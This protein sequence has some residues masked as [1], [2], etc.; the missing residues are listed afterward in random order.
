MKIILGIVLLIILYL[1]FRKYKLNKN[2]KILTY[3]FLPFL[4]EEIN[5]TDRRYFEGSLREGDD[6]I[7]VMFNLSEKNHFNKPESIKNI[8]SKCYKAI[9]Y[10]NIN[11]LNNYYPFF[12]DYYNEYFSSGIKEAYNGINENNTVKFRN[13]LYK[14]LKWKK[15]LKNNLNDIN[16]F[17]KDDGLYKYKNLDFGFKI[18]ITDDFIQYTSE[19]A[20]FS[21]HNP[22]LGIIMVSVRKN[23][24]NKN[25]TEIDRLKSYRN[26]NEMISEEILESEIINFSNNKKA[27]KSIFKFREKN[28]IYIYISY[29][30]T[31]EKYEFSVSAKVKDEN[32]SDEKR[33][34]LEKMLY[35]FELI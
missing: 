1:I 35:S 20:C 10:V 23:R 11:E 8:I 13:S 19:T 12:G 5:D 32:F 21:A 30:L 33:Y 26:T 4:R 29:F 6:F 34:Q 17:A 16:N 14:I 15:W 3:N 18:N 28:I 27:L 24:S 22:K 31:T 25:N 2:R 9:S 7:R